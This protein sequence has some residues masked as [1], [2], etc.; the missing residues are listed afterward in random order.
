MDATPVLG[1]RS[2]VGRYTA[3]LLAELAGEPALEV[4]AF[5]V[6]VRGRR[7]LRG[8]L[9]P[10]ITT[11]GPPLPARALHAAWNRLG[12]P[13]V[14][15]L[16]GRADLVHGTNFVLPPT[17]AARGVLTVH[18]LAFLDRPAELAPPQRGLPALV[19]D[20]ARRAAAVCTPSRAV[21][22]RV[23]VELGVPP[24]RLHVTPLGVDPAWFAATP[25][26]A[27]LRA[28]LRLPQRYLLF[29]GAAAPRKDLATVLAAHAATPGLPPLL[30]AGPPGWGSTPCGRH[31]GY[32]P[33]ATLRS[34]VAG[35]AA[36][37][38][39]SRDEGFGLPLL[40]A[41]ATGTPVLASDLPALR[42]VS[43][44]L[45]RHIP[46]G[47]VDAW[48]QALQE[49]PLAAAPALRQR[50]ATFTWSACGA[51]TIAAYRAALA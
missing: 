17:R 3:A 6:T 30:L 34:V 1:Q 27:A 42:E 37:V 4:R 15:L 8:L 9:P 51:A 5:A 44:G 19:A 29:V 39:P 33:E 48:C 32:L 38:L 43:G 16:A 22:E 24:D 40:E 26:D 45:A 12:A 31:L 41:F 14:E 25:P 50:A 36:L 18:D 13:P 47:D 11:A 2:G 46:P 20:A 23:R 49:L 10:G 35:A 21:A 7:A 28:R